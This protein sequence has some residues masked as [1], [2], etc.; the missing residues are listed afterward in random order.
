MAGLS[1]K[2]RRQAPAEETS[3]FAGVAERFRRAGDLERAIALC[4]EGLQKF[5]DLLSARVTLGWALLDKGDFAEARVELQAVL[6]RAPD[7]LAAIRGLAEL[8]DRVDNA[9][10]SME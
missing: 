9:E 1:L 2:R 4:R 7:N 10:G 5:P 3:A 6:K 8:H